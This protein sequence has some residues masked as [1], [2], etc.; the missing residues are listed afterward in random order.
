[1]FR[2]QLGLIFIGIDSLLWCENAVLRCISPSLLG[3]STVPL[4]G[5]T[6]DEGGWCSS[7]FLAV[8]MAETSGYSERVQTL[9]GVEEKHIWRLEGNGEVRLLRCLLSCLCGCDV[10]GQLLLHLLSNVEEVESAEGLCY[11]VF[12]LFFFLN[13]DVVSLLCSDWQNPAVVCV[14]LF[15]FQLAFF[16][17]FYFYFLHEGQ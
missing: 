3:S 12:S 5:A 7:G 10:P 14:T 11:V 2:S 9:V 1:M 8:R 16:F 17:K 13:T 6:C 4:A 15:I